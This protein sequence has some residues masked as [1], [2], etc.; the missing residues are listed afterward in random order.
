[1]KL[2]SWQVFNLNLFSAS[3]NRFTL[4]VYNMSRIKTAYGRIRLCGVVVEDASREG[5][6][7]GSNHGS[8]GASRLYAEKCATWWRGTGGWLA[9]GVPLLNNFFAI[10]SEPISK[11]PC[12]GRRLCHSP[13]LWFRGGGRAPASKDRH[14][15]WH[16]TI[17][18]CCA[19]QHKCLLATSTNRFWPS[20]RC[21]IHN[22]VP[23][24][25]TAMPR[26]GHTHSARVAPLASTTPM[27]IV[28]APLEWC[29]HS[30]LKL[31]Q[32]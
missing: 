16:K 27:Y 25:P 22:D 8:R 24:Q 18:G 30:W 21:I 23:R 15:Y 4:G 19:R 20:G 9:G 3:K 28:S 29:M 26:H 32:C 13:A 6:V 1:M 17:G 14:F 31:A 10:Y 2:F 5:E 7:T 12:V 11:I